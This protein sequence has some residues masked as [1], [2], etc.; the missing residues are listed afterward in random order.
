MNRATYAAIERYMREC[1]SDS[2][3]DCEHIYRVLYNALEIARTERAVD[4]DVLIAACLLHDIGR[5]EQF[6]DPRVDHAEAGGEKAERFLLTAGF[7]ERFCAHVKACIVTH[8]FR[9]SRPPESV[10]A[11]ILF[12]A[13]KLDVAGAMGVARTLVYKG[14]VND[15]LYSLK[16]DG[17]VS[18][19]AGDKSPSFFQEYRFKLEKIYDVFYTARGAEL[20]KKRRAGAEAFYESLLG[21]VRE[22]YAGKSE[23]DKYLTEPR[24]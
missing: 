5:K 12:D 23:L 14:G 7:D 8:R 13:D 15:P 4:C 10:E 16:P 3:H 24:K 2:A 21:E 20:A 1:M 18:D 6:A 11:R 22:T 9:K 19:G 17:S